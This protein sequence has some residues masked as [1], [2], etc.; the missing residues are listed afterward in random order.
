MSVIQNAWNVQR[1]ELKNWAYKADEPWPDQDFDLSVSEIQYSDLIIEFAIDED[2]PK[3]KFFLSCAYLLVGDAV[4]TE[5]QSRSRSE[6]EAFLGKAKSKNHKSLNTL[7]ERSV[8]LLEN[9][10][11]FDYDLWCGE[12][13]ANQEEN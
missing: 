11:S 7:Y 3:K 2:C 10:E 5:Y 4:M 8:S 13:Y 9:P 12:G 6:I 1:D